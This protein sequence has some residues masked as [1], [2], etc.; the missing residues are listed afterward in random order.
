M[1]SFTDFLLAA[2]LVRFVR[3]DVAA[4]DQTYAASAWIA[5]SHEG[6]AVPT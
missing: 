5:G 3:G 1:S 4:N 2:R 6:A